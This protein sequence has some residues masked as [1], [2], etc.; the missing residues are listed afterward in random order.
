MGVR[1]EHSPP[2]H[3]VEGRIMHWSVADYNANVRSTMFP[4][5]PRGE[6][7]RGDAGFVGEEGVAASPNTASARFG[8]AWDITGDGRT[9][10]R[11]G[12]GTFY[13]QR[14][15]GESGNGAVNAAPFSLRLAV[16]RPPG[17][18]S[19]P[20]R[21]RTDFNLI[22]DAVVGTHAGAVPDARA[23]LDLRR[24][25]QGAADLQLQPHVRAR[26]VQRPHG[27][28][29]LRRLAQPQRPT[30][31]LAELRRQE[32]RRRDHRQHRRAPP[33]RRRPVSARSNRRCRT[34][35]RTTTRCSS[36]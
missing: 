33:L 34:A 9:S 6:T 35:G 15:D 12:G 22:T 16:T 25:I 14:R 31:H 2:W 8:F 28:R 21:G 17:P 24:R 3:E 29:G 10:L 30:D 32:H 7:F 11:G 36:R 19:D 20:Y 1:F 26:T 13:D 4:A 23:D 18:F 5:A 27:A